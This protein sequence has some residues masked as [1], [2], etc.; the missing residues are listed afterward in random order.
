[1]MISEQVFAVQ[2]LWKY[3]DGQG[4]IFGLWLL[5]YVYIVQTRFKRATKHILVFHDMTLLLLSKAV[6]LSIGQRTNQRTC[7][8]LRHLLGDVY[9]CIKDGFAS[10]LPRIFAC[11]HVP[12]TNKF[13]MCFA[14]KVFHWKINDP[15]F[16][17]REEEMEDNI[18]THK[19]PAVLCNYSR[20]DIY[21]V[22]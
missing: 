15:T 4:G 3:L 1:M 6:S 13:H 12:N 17:Q 14:H 2:F 8:G 18:K 20:L 7:Q 21:D 22:W 9:E 5:K 16:R 19:T 11:A 10:V